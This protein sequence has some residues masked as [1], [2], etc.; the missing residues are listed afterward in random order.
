MN[1]PTN[2]PVNDPTNQQSSESGSRRVLT[3]RKALVLGA[4]GLGGAA[5]AVSLA[6]LGQAGTAA[7]TP[8]PKLGI[9]PSNSATENR[10]ALVKALKG[11][12]VSVTFPAGEYKIDNSKGANSNEKAVFIEGFSGTLEMASGASFVFTDNTQGGLYFHY[13]GGAKG[14]TLTGVTTK[15]AQ[16]PTKRNSTAAVTLDGATDPVVKN[17]SVTGS[18]GGGLALWGCTRPVVE[19]ATIK[20]TMADGVHFGTC[21]NGKATNVS[22]EN[23]GD[24]GLAFVNYGKA[25]M[26]GGSATNIKVVRSKARGITVVGQSGVT[27]D[28]FSVDGTRAPGILCAHE[29]EP[30]YTGVPDKVTFK[31]GTIDNGGA[32][33]GG[34]EGNN[35]GIFWNQVGEIHFS[36]IEVR[37]PGNRGVTGAAKAFTQTHRDGKTEARPAGTVHLDG[38]TVTDAPASGFNLQGGT[39][40]I[41]TLT[42]RDTGETGFAVADAELLAYGTLTAA[43]TS[44]KATL[45]RAFDFLGN[46]RIDGK[47][48][49]LDDDQATPTGYAAV[50]NGTQAGNAGTVYDK[51]AKRDIVVENPS[52]LSFKKG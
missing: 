2:D 20:D 17:V 33:E 11:T 41:G 48:L 18:T 22:T 39:Y 14:P 37:K 45:H 25:D 8:A 35:Y 12:S 29:G 51:V 13:T 28:Q 47:E 6:G 3:R 38:I 52:K 21:M 32:L 16:L 42:A 19:G 30:Y 50:F 24:D 44:K 49:H 23:T 31:N 26:T 43:R 4:A 15:Y 34:K 46:R 7:A 5:V 9:S 36:K 1:P 27:I 10:N 40:R